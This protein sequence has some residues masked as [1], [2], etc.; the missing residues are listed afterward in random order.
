MTED[1]A[2]AK[3]TFLIER[4]YVSGKEIDELAEEILRSINKDVDHEAA[5]STHSSTVKE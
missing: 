5:T 4:G 2:K 3:A 1:E